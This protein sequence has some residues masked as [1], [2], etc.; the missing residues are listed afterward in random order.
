MGSPEDRFSQYE[1]DFVSY[2]TAIISEITSIESKSLM[3][4]R[5]H[6]FMKFRA[7][8]QIIFLSFP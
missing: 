7:N 5:F 6:L 1:A 8:I 4:K 2:F 3:S